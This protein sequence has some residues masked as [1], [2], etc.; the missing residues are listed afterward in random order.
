MSNSPTEQARKELE[1]ILVNEAIP[2][3]R[4]YSTM[5]DV[6][7]WIMPC[8]VKEKLLAWHLRHAPQPPSREAIWKVINK[9][10]DSIGKPG[11]FEGAIRSIIVDEIDALFRPASLGQGSGPVWCD[12]W[13]WEGKWLRTDGEHKNMW[14][15]QETKVCH[16]CSAPRP[17]GGDG[18]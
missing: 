9:W 18:P 6:P 14:P 4:M 17:E 11:M 8:S 16:I 13:K 2:T 5:A 10:A 3:G 7:H 12:H 15:F 1:S